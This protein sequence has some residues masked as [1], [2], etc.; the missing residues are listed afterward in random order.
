MPD[1]GDFNLNFLFGNRN[2]L[3]GNGNASASSYDTNPLFGGWQS[4]PL[5]FYGDSYDGYSFNSNCGCQSNRGNDMRNLL[6]LGAL[7]LGIVALFKMGKGD[8]LQKLIQQTA[9]EVVEVTTAEGTKVKVLKSELDN[10]VVA[11]PT[12]VKS[13]VKTDEPKTVEI[14]TPNGS[15]QTVTEGTANA[16]K[17]LRDL[18]K[19]SEE[20][21]A[22]PPKKISKIELEEV[23]D[24][25][26]HKPSHDEEVENVT[27]PGHSDLTSNLEKFQTE[28]KVLEAQEATPGSA[29]QMRN[30]EIRNLKA[31]IENITGKQQTIAALEKELKELSASTSTSNLES[32]KAE[33]DKAYAVPFGE[34]GRVAKINSLEAKI[35][36]FTRMEKIKKEL[37][38]LSAS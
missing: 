28:L 1:F 11:T 36:E 14:I 38:E 20:K 3:V 15:K 9:P 25:V 23:K 21:V 31:K 2:A 8:F 29:G 10:A 22:E 37:K 33:L 5:G 34:N 12:E 4:E 13:E 16:L 30:M 32:L 24:E 26:N 7:A 19:A 27:V 17:N 35:K 6:G 18:C